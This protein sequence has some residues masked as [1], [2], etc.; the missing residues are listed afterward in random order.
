MNLALDSYPINTELHKTYDYSGLQKLSLQ[1]LPLYKLIKSIHETDECIHITLMFSKAQEVMRSFNRLKEYNVLLKK[2]AFRNIV[3]IYAKDD[4]LIFKKL[5]RF[6]LSNFNI[7]N[8]AI[9]DELKINKILYVHSTKENH[10]LYDD[11]QIDYLCDTA[12]DL[13]KID[14]SYKKSWNGL[15]GSLEYSSQ[16]LEK[17]EFKKVKAIL[18]NY[19]P[20]QEFDFLNP[21]E[22][23]KK[24]ESLEKLNFK[25]VIAY[26][27]FYPNFEIV[28]DLSD[29]LETYGVKSYL[30]KD[31][32]YNPHVKYDL[33]FVINRALG[34]SNDYFW[35]WCFC[36]A[37][38]HKDKIK[39]KI[40][41]NINNNKKFNFSYIMDL[42]LGFPL[43]KIPSIYKINKHNINNPLN[44]LLGELYELE[45]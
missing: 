19:K 13:K 39:S 26:D 34:N 18:E 23:F 45:C 7:P 35:L 43:F 1:Y 24:L 40:L 31:D 3:P 17:K 41:I 28:K 9:K 44:R 25:I 37:N 22:L 36:F 20:N 11:N 30:V 5:G 32:Y 12:V 4:L 2:V 6:D 21:L 8:I 14:N 27:D 16:F 10:T 33:K 29:Y 38:S 42:N 15:I